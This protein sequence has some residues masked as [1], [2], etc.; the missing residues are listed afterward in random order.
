[1]VTPENEMKPDAN[2]PQ[3]NQVTDTAGDK[4]YNIQNWNYAKTQRV[5]NMVKD[6]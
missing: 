3:Q 2:E 1:M 5:Y 6:F 4:D